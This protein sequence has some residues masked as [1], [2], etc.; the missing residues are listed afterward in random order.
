MKRNRNNPRRAALIIAAAI[1][2]GTLITASSILATISYQRR[3]KELNV[4]AD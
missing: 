1:A 3:V 4:R 2:A